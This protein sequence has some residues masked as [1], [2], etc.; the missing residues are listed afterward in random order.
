MHIRPPEDNTTRELLSGCLL[1]YEES[2]YWADEA[3]QKEDLS[4]HGSYVKAYSLKWKK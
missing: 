2:V 1:V 3:L 4:Y